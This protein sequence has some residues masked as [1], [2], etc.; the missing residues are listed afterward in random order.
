VTLQPSRLVLPFAL[1]FVLSQAHLAY[2]LG[3]LSPNLVA[4]QLT[5]DDQAFWS[6]M[7]QWGPQGMARLR[8]S[9]WPWDMLHPFIYAGLGYLLVMH[10][11]LFRGA[12]TPWRGVLAWML[13]LAGVCDLGENVCELSLLALPFGT[14]SDLIP[15]SA[16]LS[17]IKWGLAGIF[18]VFILRAAIRHLRASA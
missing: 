10:T 14:P 9:M 4:V 12:T 3:A 7:A 2:V 11:R 5:F 13:M 15:L 18:T 1:A 6:A 16:G 17:L 8:A